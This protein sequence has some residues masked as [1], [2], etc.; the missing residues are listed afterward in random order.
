MSLQHSYPRIKDSLSKK[1]TI[2]LESAQFQVDT[3]V[4]PHPVNKE[5]RTFAILPVVNL[6]MMK[7][8]GALDKILQA[9]VLSNSTWLTPVSMETKLQDLSPNCADECIILDTTGRDDCLEGL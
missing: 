3:L 6:C 9:T 5:L 1:R 7:T 2:P 4:Y 8:L